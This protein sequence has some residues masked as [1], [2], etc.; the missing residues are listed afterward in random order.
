MQVP[1][2]PELHRKS[3]SQNQKERED[4][5]LPLALLFFTVTLYSGRLSLFRGRRGLCQLWADKAEFWSCDCVLT[6]TMA[7]FRISHCDWPVPAG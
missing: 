7:Q 2:Q 5:F 3:L 4:L 6:Q 1:D